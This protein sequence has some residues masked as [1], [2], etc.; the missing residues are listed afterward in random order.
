MRFRALHNMP[1]AS[2]PPH[3]AQQE[4]LRL[5]MFTAGDLCGSMLVKASPLDADTV[6][7][8]LYIYISVGKKNRPYFIK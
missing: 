8:I 5:V 1:G 4:V 2:P 7:N 6:L 3:F